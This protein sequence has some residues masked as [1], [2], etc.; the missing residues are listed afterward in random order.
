[1]DLT[2]ARYI[3]VEGPIGAGKSTLARRL[4]EALGASLLL[5]Q[6]E[7]NPFLPG[8]YEDP[9]RHALSTQLFFL[10][11][12]ARQL[13]GLRQGDLFQPRTVADFMW[14]KDRLFAAQT[15]SADELALYDQVHRALSTSAPTPDLVIYLQA[16]V[17]LLLNRIRRRGI[18]YEQH[19]G[20]DYLQEL[21]AAYNHFF[22]QYDASPLLIVNAEHMDFLNSAD[23]LALLLARFRDVRGRLYLNARA[24]G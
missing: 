18:A 8:F 11:Q 23:D 16:P 3:V 19:I 24:G 13:E 1:M 4:G 14:E 7:E 20:S 5:E 2:D 12:R 6:A 15:L 22:H 9:A 10:L 21:V 17:E